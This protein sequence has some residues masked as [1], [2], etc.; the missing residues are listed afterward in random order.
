MRNKIKRM[1]CIFSATSVVAL[2]ACS[3][4]PALPTFDS[5]L[6]WHDASGA[7][8][9]LL[10]Y[11]VAVYDTRNGS[12]DDVRVK[13]ADGALTFELTE[14]SR[15]DGDRSYSSLDMNF[16]VKYNDS[17]PEA[18]R[19]KTDRI[20]STTEFATTSLVTSKMHK[21]VNLEEREGVNDYS[22]TI[23]A[24]YFDKHSATMDFLDKQLSISIP[25]GMYYDNET[26]FYLARA[27]ALAAGGST[28]F[29]LTGL[30]DCFMNGGFENITMA[31]ST[32]SSLN[33]VYLGDWVKDF[34]VEGVT[35]DDGVTAYPISCYNTQIAMNVEKHGPP[36]Y[37]LYSEKPFVQNDKEH[38]KIPVFMSFSEYERGKLVRVTEYTLSA[39]AFDKA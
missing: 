38:N 22:Y 32:A 17:A 27:T 37:V 18:D 23:D 19:N 29:Y 4:V 10:D 11:T 30:F 39:C 21:S 33:T 24:D 8:Y 3:N 36:Y 2:T 14:E 15:V 25:S 35:D 34:G 28:T 6:P 1:L 26:M 16:S 5:E 12:G 20:A 13:I 31:T 7:S 9:E